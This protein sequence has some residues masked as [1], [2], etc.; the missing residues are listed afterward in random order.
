MIR[1]ADLFAPYL[2]RWSLTADGAPFRSLSSDLLPVRRDGRPAM[3]KVTDE[4]EERYG[5]KLMAWWHGDGAVAVLAMDE[6]ALLLERA[7][8]PLYLAVMAREGQDDEASRVLCRVAERLHAP[9][10]KPALDAIPLAT[11]F[12]ALE[13]AAR[14]EGGI[15]ARSA[16]AA[17]AL[18]A[19]PQDEVLLHGDLH[20][21]NVLDGGERGWLAIDP[22][23]V[24]GER[25]FEF[26]NLFCNPDHTTALRPGRL[27]RQAHVV[28]KAA[29]LDR[30]RLLRWVLAW[31]GLSAVWSIEDGDE[32]VASRTLDIAR[33]AAAELGLLEA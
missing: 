15:L 30:T 7:T 33:L 26:A 21:G 18:L 23:R 29:G 5:A 31:A 32:D 13:P 17:Q 11:R 12:E 2:S 10:A 25:G 4:P 20:H 14:R 1:N 16:E 27:A 19:A 3:L 8:G 24:R 9:R 22:K 6:H 28:A